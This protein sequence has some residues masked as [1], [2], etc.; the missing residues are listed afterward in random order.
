MSLSSEVIPTWY[1]S[2]AL[3]GISMTL[4]YNKEEDSESES[5]E[6]DLLDGIFY[7]VEYLP[8]IIVYDRFIP[9]DRPNST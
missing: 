2:D 3:V 7:L 5:L 6:I 1:V 8:E 9:I 4:D